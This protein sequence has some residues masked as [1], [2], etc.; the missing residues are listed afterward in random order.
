MLKFAM[1]AAVATTTV[2]FASSAGAADLRVFSPAN[3]AIHISL[4]GKA[5]AQVKAEIAAAANIVCAADASCLSA[6]L[7]DANNQ[8]AAIAKTHTA[9]SPAVAA[10][11][12]VARADPSTVHVSLVG[13]SQAQIDA[14]I[15]DA[16]QTVCKAIDANDFAACVGDAINDAKAQLRYMA[17]ADQPRQLASN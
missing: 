8:L 13:K 2:V 11:V 17:M 4:A 12:E 7:E 9:A 10:N 16:A 3:Q 14:D 5:E 15:K 1:L 6:T